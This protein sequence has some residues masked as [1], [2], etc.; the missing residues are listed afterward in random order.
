VCRC[1]PGGGGV[2][3]PAAPEGARDQARRGLAP[4][5]LTPGRRVRGAGTEVVKI[6]DQQRLE[7][8]HAADGRLAA[9]TMV[10]RPALLV[11]G[12]KYLPMGDVRFR[13]AAAG[14]PAAPVCKARRRRLEWLSAL[15]N[16]GSSSEQCSPSGCRCA[17]RCRRPEGPCMAGGAVAS[18]RARRRSAGARR[19]L[20]TCPEQLPAHDVAARSAC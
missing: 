18:R 3:R 20:V 4:G 17:A 13:V 19:L 6:R 10:S 11:P 15:C 1:R 12:G 8:E 9:M 14:S 5:E 16:E 7:L 2:P